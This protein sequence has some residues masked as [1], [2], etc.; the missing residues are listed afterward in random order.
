MGVT[1]AKY[2]FFDMKLICALIYRVQ[3]ES[4]KGLQLP[5]DGQFT[6]ASFLSSQRLTHPEIPRQNRSTRREMFH[7][8]L[9]PPQ[10]EFSVTS[11]HQG[12]HQSFPNAT[13]SQHLPSVGSY[14]QS[15]GKIIQPQWDSSG[16]RDNGIHEGEHQMN[17]LLGTKPFQII[18]NGSSDTRK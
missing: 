9:S 11:S 7:N 4:P 2:R 18:G 17:S 13:L 10:S 16:I 5:F 14:F 1:T 15:P 6:T 8:V 12:L 3:P